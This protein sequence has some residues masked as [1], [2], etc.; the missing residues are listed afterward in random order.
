MLP[1]DSN[2]IFDE[3]A[4]ISTGG[5]E[6][7]S[8]L[9]EILGIKLVLEPPRERYYLGWGEECLGQKPIIC[10]WTLTLHDVTGKPTSFTFDLVRGSSPLILGQDIRQ[11]C[12]TFN[13]SAQKYVCMRRPTE[14]G[15]RYLYTYLVAEDSRLCLDLAPH[16]LSVTKTLL[17]N[18]HT[19]AKRAPLVFC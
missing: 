13:L 4:P 10:S 2:P 3:G 17:G 16:P 12:N 15:D 19:T 11:Y 18:I 5:I 1:P 7:A 6:N 9:S 8:T 14:N